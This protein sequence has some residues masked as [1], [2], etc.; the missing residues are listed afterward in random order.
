MMKATRVTVIDYGIGNLLSVARALAACG[1]DVEVTGSGRSV[2]TG[3]RV[4]LP[5]VGAF[6]SCM[7]ELRRRGLVESLLAFIASGRPFLGICVGLQMLM[8]VSEE[9]GEHPGLGLVAGRVTAIPSTT[10]DGRPHKIPHIGWSALQPR[11][12]GAA[13]RGGILDAV[14]ASDRCYFVHSFAVQPQARRVRL[15]DCAY[16]GRIFCAAIRQDNIHGTQFH[17]EKSGKTGLNILS[18]F[19][20]QA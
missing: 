14:T 13:W 10:A 6:T 17:P 5:G 2:E 11:E 1:A 20:K 16:D 18:S 19:L 8:E 15:A 9:F 4:V 3:E 7:N 12:G